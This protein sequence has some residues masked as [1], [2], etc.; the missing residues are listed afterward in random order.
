[1]TARLAGCFFAGALALTMLP[2][3]TPVHE[4]YVTVPG[5][6]IFYRDTGGSGT[7][8]VL[9]HAATGSS[10]VWDFQF[11]A[12]AAA[13]YRVIAFDRRGWGRT[14]VTSAG[15]ADTAADDLL[16]LLDQ[17]H[18]DRGHVIGTAAGGFVALDFA[19]SYPQRVR[20]LVV[21]NSIGGVQD[22]D[23]VEMGRR[24]R[25]PEFDKL[26]PEIREVGPSYR[27][28]NPDG[29]ARWVELEKISRPPGP[30]AAA[31]PLRNHITF[32]LLENIH[33]PT[34][35]MT[36]DADLYAPPPILPLFAARIKGAETLVIPEAGHSAYWEQPET[37]N[38][39]VLEFIAKH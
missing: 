30:R 23:Y 32:A 13:G 22:A 8:V 14:E 21:A 35:L 38:R 29:T 12:F 15:P 25:P 26:P 18:L 2:A 6:R 11:S 17:L 27:A 39:A 28:A 9:L 34:L 31:Q 20:S 36:G 19:L 5:A 4:G 33:A 24:L 37:F 7:P 3:E 10:R 1:M 16:A